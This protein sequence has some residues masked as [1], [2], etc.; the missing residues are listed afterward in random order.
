MIYAG[1]VM[2]LVV[3]TIMAA[4]SRPESP[5]S[6]S[7]LLPRWLAVIGVLLPLAEVVFMALQVPA[8][9]AAPASAGFALQP[10]LA[11]VLFGPYAVATE[12]VTLLMFIAGLAVK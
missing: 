9:A 8:T 4:P 11:A 2:V 7:P 6:A 10:S 12:A 5:W 3:V 1:A